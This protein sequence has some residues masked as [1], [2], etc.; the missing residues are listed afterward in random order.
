MVFVLLRIVTLS[1]VKI[2]EQPASQSWPM[3]I[4]G[5]MCG[6]V[7]ASLAVGGRKGRGSSPLWVV[8]VVLPS[9]IVMLMVVFGVGL[10]M[11]LMEGSRCNVSP[12][13]A[14]GLMLCCWWMLFV[15]G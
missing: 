4:S 1:A 12:V 3:D 10:L 11:L 2:S 13:S 15:L 6:I 7:C 8:F 5:V 9:A 14:T